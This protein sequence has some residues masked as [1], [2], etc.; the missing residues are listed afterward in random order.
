[1]SFGQKLNVPEVRT[2]PFQLMG[3]GAGEHPP[4]PLLPVAPKALSGVPGTPAGRGRVG[5]CPP[6]IIRDRSTH[7]PSPLTA[8]LSSLCSVPLPLSSA[9]SALGYTVSFPLSLSEFLLLLLRA[10][11][12][13]SCCAQGRHLAKGAGQSELGVR[14]CAGVRFTRAASSACRGPGL[15]A[16]AA[17]AGE[18]S[19]GS[20]KSFK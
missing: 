10:L 4:I 13:E 20:K 1:M 3:V 17:A 19:R 15:L 14:V 9:N 12:A 7:R 5:N 16:R 6:L 11:R 2:E 18:A 8:H